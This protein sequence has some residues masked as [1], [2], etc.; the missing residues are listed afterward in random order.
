MIPRVVIAASLALELISL[1]FFTTRPTEWLW[2]GFHLAGLILFFFS[3]RPQRSG[4]VALALPVPFIGLLLLIY[5]Q[6]ITLAGVKPK[7][8]LDFIVGEREVVTTPGKWSRHARRSIVDILHGTDQTER[9]R[10]V[11]LLR[12]IDPK[13]SLPILKKAIQDSDE[14][15]R[16]LAQTL[17][18]KII[19]GLELDIKTREAQLEKV[20]QSPAIMLQLAELYHE[21]VYLGLASEESEKLY[22][23]RAEQLASEAL[24]FSQDHQPA[25]FLLLRCH[26]KAQDFEAAKLRLTQLRALGFQEE[27]LLPWELEIYF[28][29]KNWSEFKKL[30]LKFRREFPTSHRLRE[31]T[32]FWLQATY[33][34][35]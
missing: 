28:S 17:F 3:A 26:V 10:A 1:W 5:L 13:K 24:K 8:K 16:L 21:L 33:A 15:V 4:L 22:L 14:Q 23:E 30:L 18:S 7:R 29:Q 27:A 34:A 31:Q 6:R 25:L 20:A 32:D 9:R 19:S 2:V 12:Q 11:L 35:S